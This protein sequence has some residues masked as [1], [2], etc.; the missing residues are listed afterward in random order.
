MAK[1]GNGHISEA[2]LLRYLG[3][4]RHALDAAVL[5]AFGIEGRIDWLDFPSCPNAT[6]KD[7]EW[8]GIEFL[9]NDLVH[10]CRW[11]AI[12]DAWNTYWPQTSSHLAP[13]L[14]RRVIRHPTPRSP[15][16]RRSQLP[17]LKRPLLVSGNAF[18]AIRFGARGGLRVLMRATTSSPDSSPLS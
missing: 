9:R 17:S 11:I 14:P 1:M 2:H 7:A 10:G 5:G 12:L 3:Q 15:R 6:R 18:T 16:V 4:H 13:G 8:T